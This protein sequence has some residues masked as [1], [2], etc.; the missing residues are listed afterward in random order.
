MKKAIKKSGKHLTI[1]GKKYTKYSTRE[2]TKSEAV[3]L[4]ANM[5]SKGDIN[6]QAIEQPSGKYYVYIYEK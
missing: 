1:R 6:A 3:E 2:L 5:R 4:A